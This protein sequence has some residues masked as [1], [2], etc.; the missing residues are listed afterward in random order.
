MATGGS[1]HSQPGH[2]VC[3]DGSIRCETSSPPL[4]RSTLRTDRT[5]ARIAV[6]DEDVTFRFKDHK[7]GSNFKDPAPPADGSE[8]M[9]TSSREH[10]CNDDTADEE[11]FVTRPAVHGTSAD[12]QL[13][14]HSTLSTSQSEQVGS[15]MGRIYV[16][17]NSGS[18]RD[19]PERH[20]TVPFYL[21]VALLSFL[22]N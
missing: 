16:P 17:R 18:Q 7:P 15:A 19:E 3:D 12:G 22:T 2:G 10:Q 14:Q 11:E 4:P 20:V 9:E 5:G 8:F 21:F 13:T 6:A 1:D